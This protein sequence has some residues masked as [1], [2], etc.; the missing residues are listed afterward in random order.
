MHLTKCL[1]PR[2]V[3]NKYTG[4]LVTVSCGKCEACISRRQVLLCNKFTAECQCW[5]YS[6]F[7]TLTYSNDFVPVIYHDRDSHSFF[8]KGSG[9]CF[10]Y[11]DLITDQRNFDFVNESE[12]LYRVKVEDAQNFIKRL[13]KLC[14]KNIPENENN[15][16]RYAIVGEYGETLARPHYHGILWFSSKWLASHIEECISSAWS[17]CGESIGR[18]DCSF[19]RSSAPQYVSTY[20]TGSS[21]LPQ[22]YQHKRLKP[23]CLYSK[24]PSIG[25]LFPSSESIKDIVFRGSPKFFCGDQCD[26][27]PVYVPLWSDI[28]NTLFPKI[29]GFNY[30]NHSERVR[31]YGA[32]YESMQDEFDSFRAWCE[33]RCSEK[34]SFDFLS[35]Y[36]EVLQQSL[37]RVPPELFA[38]GSKYRNSVLR[39]LWYVGNRVYFQ[40]CSFGISLSD[41]VSRIE[42]HYN[43]KALDSLREWYQWQSDYV[44][45][46][47]DVRDLLY[48]DL[49]FV[50]NLVRIKDEN[51]L[52]FEQ[53][54]VLRNYGFNSFTDFV[55]FNKSHTGFAGTFDYKDYSQKV[56]WRSK[57]N[58]DKK[59]QNEYLQQNKEKFINIYHYYTYGKFI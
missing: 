17:L 40:S 16:L 37:G 59:R 5:P 3:K 44:S 13:R 27:K 35:R 58:K 6:V 24:C 56:I 21:S 50:S 34:E 39:R 41:Y 51:D 11:D 45:N 8:E 14:Y 10:S 49:C 46:G 26:G 31:L 42:E 25:S 28:E 29:S 43:K 38:V 30:F 19:I 36:F 57:Q 4:Q 55:G 12:F 52:T 2:V 48:S 53:K 18:V 9:E 33:S 20:C 15:K 47:H 32:A 7:F 22:I 23:F 54:L 1:Y